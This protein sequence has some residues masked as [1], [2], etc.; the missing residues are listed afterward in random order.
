MKYPIRV[1]ASPAL[2]GI[3]VLA[4]VASPARAVILTFSP[5]A[6]EW[7][8]TGGTAT[9]NHIWTTGDYWA[10]NFP[11]TGLSNASSMALRLFIDDNALNP[12]N[13][14]DLNVLLNANV[15]GNI[16][17][18]SG[19]SGPLD[20]NFAFGSIVGPNYRIQLL[21]TNT[22]PS[23]DGSVS[24]AVDG[25]S[26]AVLVPEPDELILVAGALASFLFVVVARRYQH[27]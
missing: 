26:F 3:V 2:W 11:A 12:S 21:A 10:Q 16:A 17:I 9:P 18:P 22:I 13:T 8:E 5:P 27:A 25:R 1:L 24:M 15:I 7:F 6:F 14:L 4:V 23:G 19:V 20:Y